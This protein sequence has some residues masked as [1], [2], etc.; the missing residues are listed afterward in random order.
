VVEGIRLE[1]PGEEWWCLPWYE[2]ATPSLVQ[3]FFHFEMNYFELNL[4]PMVVQ[5]A[6]VA[7]DPVSLPSALGLFLVSLVPLLWRRKRRGDH[8]E[9]SDVRGREAVG[10]GG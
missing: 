9:L 8:E 5:S 7:P 1:C 2:D 3:Y 6:P 10:R 4:V